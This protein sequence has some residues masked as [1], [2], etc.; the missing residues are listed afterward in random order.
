[1]PR[2]KRLRTGDD[3]AGQQMGPSSWEHIFKNRVIFDNIC[4]HMDPQ[5]ILS[6]RQTTKQLSGLFDSLFKT[7]WNVNRSLKRFV[8]NPVG[9]RSML[10]RH[11][12]LISGSFALQFFERVVWDDSDLDI[13]VHD[14]DASINAMGQYLIQA[15]NYKFDSTFD[16]RSPDYQQHLK[17]VREVKT[18][19]RET[20]DSKTKENHPLKI[21]IIRTDATPLETI[22]T[23]FYTTV[24]INFISWD[25]AWSVFPDL[26]FIKR[27]SYQLKNLSEYYGILIGK[28]GRRG[29]RTL[30]DVW[31]E[32]TQYTKSLEPGKIRSVGDSKSWKI[33]LDTT[34]VSPGCP[35]SVVN[36]CFFNIRKAERASIHDDLFRPHYEIDAK[37]WQSA[38]LKYKYT[39][40]GYGYEDF[41]PHISDRLQNLTKIE[42]LKLEDDERPFPETDYPWRYAENVRR[43][44]PAGWAFWDDHLEMWFKAYQEKADIKECD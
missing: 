8:D 21:Q 23:G 1:M 40:P 30:E 3:S 34:D 24:I 12:A 31:P 42:L 26:S 33:D 28:Y 17:E 4:R 38:V 2:F 18:Y 11:N 10:A 22:L 36:Y 9:L 43:H 35:S 7:Q 6:L 37:G 39:F 13:Y 25:S 19:L 41:W 14:D 32:D 20:E 44:P 16:W 29:W 15:E 5:G 27:K